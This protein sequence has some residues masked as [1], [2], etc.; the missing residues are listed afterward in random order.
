LDFINSVVDCC[1]GELGFEI[2]TRHQYKAIV[3]DRDGKEI[4]LNSCLVVL[5]SN[6]I[7]IYHKN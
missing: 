4:E 1:N 2:F 6:D 5:R 3:K 7:S